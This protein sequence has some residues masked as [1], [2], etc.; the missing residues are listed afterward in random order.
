MHR[1]MVLLVYYAID[2]IGICF[3]V[4]TIFGL[5]T[6]NAEKYRLMQEDMISSSNYTFQ[7]DDVAI[8]K[9]S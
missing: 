4:R 7:I 6:L 8:D 9:N 2:F 1:T 5:D 3:M